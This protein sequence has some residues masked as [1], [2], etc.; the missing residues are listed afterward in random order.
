LP[1]MPTRPTVEHVPTDFPGLLLWGVP[2]VIVWLAGQV[3]I[4]R[5]MRD[6]GRT[7][8]LGLRLTMAGFGLSLLGWLIGLEL[9]ALDRSEWAVGAVM[10]VV[11]GPMS[12]LFFWL[13]LRPRV[14]AEE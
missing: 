8:P 2:G 12:V 1:L 5:A 11:L 4:F 3:L 14:T 13:A 7:S 9:A 6:G 10:L